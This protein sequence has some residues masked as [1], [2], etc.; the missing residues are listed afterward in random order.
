MQVSSS[1]NLL[2]VAVISLLTSAAIF[3]I[4]FSSDIDLLNGLS[5]LGVPELEQLVSCPG[6]DREVD[7]IPGII[8]IIS[9]TRTL[10]QSPT[11]PPLHQD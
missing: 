10:H 5:R 1:D 2:S 9:G 8:V 6:D 4:L 7:M 3:V 11:S